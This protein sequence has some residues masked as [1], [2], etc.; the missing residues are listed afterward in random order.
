MLSLQRGW[1]AARRHVLCGA[2][3]AV[4]LA[5]A[6]CGGPTPPVDASRAIHFQSRL[7]QA[8]A[9]DISSQGG[10]VASYTTALRPCGGSVVLVPGMSGVPATELLITLLFDPT[11]QLDLQLSRW[12]DD[13]H[14]LPGSFSGMS[15]LWSTGELQ[16]HSLP[17][18]ITIT[19][20]IVFVEDTPPAVDTTCGRWVHQG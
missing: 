3:L 19:P 12:T 2:P 9:V 18:W 17:R 20:D 14:D 11:G 6:A 13:P 15:I 10:G 4:V 16:P 5:V 1:R 7:N 8:V